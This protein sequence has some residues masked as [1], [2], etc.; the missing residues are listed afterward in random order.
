MK[1]LLIAAESPKIHHQWFL[2]SIHARWFGIQDVSTANWATMISRRYFH[3]LTRLQKMP[4]TSC[5]TKLTN[6]SQD[7]VSCF[8]NKI[9]I[10]IFFPN[11]KGWI[12]NHFN[13]LEN[14]V[15]LRF[16]SLVEELQLM[17]QRYKDDVISTEKYICE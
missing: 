10:F 12:N 15:E 16:D 2:S 3:L 13:Y 8:F 6:V 14:D 9:L 4:A 7:S 17:R 5:V 11:Y 1:P